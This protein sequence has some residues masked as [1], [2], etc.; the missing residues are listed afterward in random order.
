MPRWRRKREDDASEE[1]LEEASSEQPVEP[2]LTEEQPAVPAE[3]DPAPEE[4]PDW[5]YEERP[6][7]GRRSRR[8]RRRKG[9]KD[10]EAPRATVQPEAFDQD[11]VP[12]GDP[13]VWVSDE[14][15]SDEHPSDE[16][17]EGSEHLGAPP[18]D[19]I[20]EAAV[21]SFEEGV[22]DEPE[23]TGWSADPI[24]PSRGEQHLRELDGGEARAAAERDEPVVIVESAAETTPPLEHR[25]PEDLAYDSREAQAPESSQAPAP[26]PDGYEDS[27]R[28]YGYG[29]YLSSEAG[30]PED[31]YDE[32]VDDDPDE[33][34]YRSVPGDVV[35]GG[36]GPRRAALHERRRKQKRLALGVGAAL[37]VATI[38]GISALAG[39]ETSDEDDP[40]SD[41]G[42]IGQ[43]GDDRV[44][45]MLLYGTSE[46]ADEA[47]A[48]W[49][50]LLSIDRERDKGSVVYI[51]AH[52]AVEV[53]GRGLLPLGE[54]VS[55]EEVAL[56]TVTTEGLLGIEIDSYLELSDRDARVLFSALG[57]LEVDV[58]SEVSVPAGSGQTQ[59]IFTEGV[60]PVAGEEVEDLLYETGVEG[61]DV[62]LGARHLAFWDALLD[63]FGGRTEELEDA[64][65]SSES[66]LGESDL[67]PE[68]I[69]DFLSDLAAFPED[70]MVLNSLPVTQVSVG[71]SELY[72]T[73]EEEVE[74]FVKDTIGA[75]SSVGSE[76][77]VQ[78]LN[79]NGVPG[80]GEEVAEELV[81]EGYRV[82]LS[83][84]ARHLNYKKT[85]VIAYERTDEA[86]A[87]A[88]R[89]R[90][91]IGVGEVQI[92][93]QEQ[94]I[95]DLTIVVGKD[96]LGRT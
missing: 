86:I 73:E 49:L 79:G 48:I 52:T 25:D 59:L 10:E 23:E 46:E 19:P 15:P 81:G 68:E 38:I 92:S 80:I 65:L 41:A 72:S 28:D 29:P 54:A 45:T 69:A 31:A 43:A 64:V 96:F 9:R 18:E 90:E 58:P 93:G 78:I 51:P 3:E 62:E 32:Q 24:W 16:Q 82:F 42:A 84:N 40:G 70:S 56:L 5:A 14:Q 36:V 83:G 85:L 39:G 21:A 57:T 34:S 17:P 74:R 35:P 77:R 71:E 63:T 66:V 7:R 55:G 75:R 88:E 53:P 61:D 30:E 20:E 91:L 60:Q 50:T 2:D 13:A 26:D 76:I 67:S 47:G 1:I 94:G 11:R 33:S 95:V 44:E 8:S 22:E 87:L 6:R 27:E 37:V 12:D 4:W 89:A